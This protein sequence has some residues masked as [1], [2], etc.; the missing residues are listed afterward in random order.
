M[1]TITEEDLKA[2]ER[3]EAL[4]EKF[5]DHKE[6]DDDLINLVDEDMM[7]VYLLLACD[8]TELPD[9]FVTLFQE[10]LFHIVSRAM[11]FGYSIAR[12]NI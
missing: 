12:T 4:V 10:K 6:L 11:A 7:N 8:E 2:G 1:V 9:L 5:G 3:L